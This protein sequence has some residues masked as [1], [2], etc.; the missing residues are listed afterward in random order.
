MRRFDGVIFDMDGTLIDTDLDFAAI[1]ADLGIAPGMGILETIEQMP[2]PTRNAAH[3]KLLSHE[4]A[5]ADGAQLIPGALEV[6]SIIRKAGMKLAILTRNAEP[7]VKIILQR[8]DQLQFDLAF[9]RED[10]P[11]KPEPD[12]VLRACEQLGITPAR[13]ACVG[14]FHYDITA[15]NS[16]GA[17][18]ILFA[19]GAKGEFAHEA[20]FVIS[21]LAELPAILG[22]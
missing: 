11:I 10:G 16:A 13:A 8:F 4:L 5:A 17:V 12:G 6:I 22:I 18:S 2:G 1:R 14:D 3:K 7:V 21:A 19:P 9:S 20:D 15:A